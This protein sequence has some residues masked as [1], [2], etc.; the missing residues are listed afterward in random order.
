MKDI[1]KLFFTIFLLLFIFEL[2]L[3]G[4]GFIFVALCSGW[5]MGKFFI[6]ILL[7]GS[8]SAYLT[9]DIRKEKK[10]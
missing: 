6:S 10:K 8:I 2:S 5:E 1:L 4:L 7:I 3:L 9:Y